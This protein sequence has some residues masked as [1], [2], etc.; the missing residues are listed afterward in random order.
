[1]CV[2]SL[3]LLA[4]IPVDSRPSVV[5]FWGDSRVTCRFST[6]CGSVPLTHT[7]L[8]SAVLGSRENTALLPTV[9]TWLQV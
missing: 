6:V 2:D 4:R 3:M 1:M 8:G 5:K 7:L 9:F